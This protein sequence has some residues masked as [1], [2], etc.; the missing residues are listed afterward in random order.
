MEP[1]LGRYRIR[2]GA[3]VA[4]A[5]GTGAPVVALESTILSHGLPRPMN[6]EVGGEIERT[7]RAA[8]AVPATVGVLGGEIWV[9]L[10]AGQLEHL[11]LTD[12]VAKASVRDLPVVAAKGLDGAT[13]VASTA[14]IAAAAGIAVFATGGLGGV[15][16]AAS[17]TFDESADLGALSRTPIAVV[18]AGVKSILD[19]PATLERLESSGVTVLG[20]RTDRFPGF[21]LSDSGYPIG[22]RAENPEEI[23]DVLRAARELKLGSG[24]VVVANPLPVDEQLDPALHD[25]VLA[26]GL[27]GLEREH[28]TGKDVTPY[29][30][31]HFHS[32]T[33]GESLTVNTRIILR[34]AE[35]AGRI[36]VAF[37]G[38]RT[39]LA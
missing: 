10:D 15:H 29:L 11:A 13:T 3:D 8:G 1:P 24:A 28:V 22:W 7:V 4:E 20:Y 38:S 27:A 23:A 16:R 36:A 35:L 26:E 34:N 5:L 30:L 19:V 17:T 31:A 2:L 37:A 9:G 33:H 12:G 25:R 39:V 14:A 6:L 21:Y 32:A 18:C